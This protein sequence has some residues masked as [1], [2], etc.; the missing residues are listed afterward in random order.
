MKDK[1]MILIDSLSK[2]L[3]DKYIRLISSNMDDPDELNTHHFM[4]VESELMSLFDWEHSNEGY[5]FWNEVHLYMIELG[6]LPMLPVDISY[7]ADTVMYSQGSIYIMNLSGSGAS[8][9]YECPI[10]DGW[11]NLSDELK[12]S[13][14]G[15]LN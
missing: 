2:K 13:V 9:R 10:D 5:G 1:N 6:D 12:E 14:L 3:P 7:D 11:E 4:P 15:F 8:I